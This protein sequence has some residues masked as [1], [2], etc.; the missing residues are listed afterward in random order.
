MNDAKIK[1]MTTIAMLCAIAYVAMLTVRIPV[2]LFLKYEPKDII[3]A[4]GGFVMG[5]MAAFTVSL[6]VGL[7]EMFTAS[8]TGIIGFI[9]NVLS[10][11]SFACT[12]ALI[13]KKMRNLK[14]AVM[15]LVVG[16]VVM[17]A[18]MLLWN[19]LI[20]PLYMNLPRA[21]VAKLLIPAILPFNILKGSLNSAITFLIYKPVVS[22]LRRTNLVAS[23]GTAA[24]SSV[25]FS[26]AAA[27]I[28][29]TCIL[30]VLAFNGKI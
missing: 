9:M 8:D 2:V 29:I 27:I 5:P 10:S 13:Y 14:G 4:V 22:A 12:A 11:C 25:G 26:I 1:K 3:I 20:T 19:Y 18:V 16:T 24:K 17:V 28:L 30:A 15:G 21:E 6:V 23:S 7:I